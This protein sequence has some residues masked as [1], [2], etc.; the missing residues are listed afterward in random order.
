MT[1][2]TLQLTEEQRKLAL[3][4]AC[5]K[6]HVQTLPILSIRRVPYE[7]DMLFIIS[8]PKGAIVRREMQFVMDCE[9]SGTTPTQA[10][11]AFAGGNVTGELQFWKEGEK[12]QL[13]DYNS[14]VKSGQKAAGEWAIA[15]KAGSR[16]SSGFLSLQ[17][18][19]SSM[20]ALLEIANKQDAER[21]RFKAFVGSTPAASN[22]IPDDLD[23][24]GSDNTGAPSVQLPPV[25]EDG[26]P[27]DEGN[28]T[29]KGED[30]GNQTPETGDSNAAPT[31][32]A[33]AKAGKQG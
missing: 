15:T 11:L 1:T 23:L 3:A 28:G 29:G 33:G 9:S 17:A 5:E 18:P 31:A 10:L 7:G 12:Y 25:T 16:L 14:L 30:Q 2:E 22:D 19:A 6:E 13:Q 4:K 21:A 27:E 24:E 8:T 32:K 26:K 20:S